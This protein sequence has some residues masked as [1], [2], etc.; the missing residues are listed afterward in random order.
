LVEKSNDT[1]RKKRGNQLDIDMH[2]DMAD[3]VATTEEK[4]GVKRRVSRRSQI[5]V[6]AGEATKS[7]AA[8]TSSLGKRARD[9]IDAVK[10]KASAATTRTTRASVPQSPPKR[11]KKYEPTGRLFPNLPHAQ[12]KDD[13]Q[14]EEP[15]PHE[16]S[17]PVKAPKIQKIYQTKGLY[18]GQKR[19]FNAMVKE[20]TNMKKQSE[21]SATEALTEN[22]L[23]PLPMFGTFKRLTV[24][25]SVHFAP[26][27]LPADILMPLKKEQNPKDWSKLSKSRYRPQA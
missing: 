20:G 13:I 2:W 8:A 17:K 6:S 12:P 24:D 7:I 23:L 26:F 9:A 27:K 22:S 11:A 15:K 21:T 1:P 5:G 4:D 16:P 14:E 10:G 3:D 19:T 18:A 25:D